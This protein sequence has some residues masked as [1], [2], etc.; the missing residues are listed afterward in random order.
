MAAN[1]VCPSTQAP[2]PCD[3]THTWQERNPDGQLKSDPNL[4]AL[5]ITGYLVYFPLIILLL[6]GGHHSLLSCSGE[7]PVVNSSAGSNCCTC[8]CQSTLQA[9][10]QELKTMRKLMQIQAGMQIRPQREALQW[11][12]SLCFDYTVPPALLSHLFFFLIY[13]TSFLWKYSWWGTS[14]SIHFSLFFPE[15][16][17]LLPSVTDAF[18]QTLYMCSWSFT[19]VS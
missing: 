12:C 16:T 10:L 7:L 5:K 2:P 4:Q 3:T 11:G 6:L 8:N 13:L 14:S 17:F 1:C 9:I 15:P 18:W 19:N